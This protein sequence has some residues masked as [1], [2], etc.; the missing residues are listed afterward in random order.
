MIDFP[1]NY[2]YIA[3]ILNAAIIEQYQQNL[4]IKLFM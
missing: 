2:M 1:S 4:R 3:P